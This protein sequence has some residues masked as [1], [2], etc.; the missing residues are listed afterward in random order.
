MAYGKVIH[1]SVNRN[2]F[3]MNSIA[4]FPNF[5]INWIRKKK[6]KHRAEKFIFY[7]T[8]RK[9]R[10][11][12]SHTR[13]GEIKFCFR[14]FPN[15]NVRYFNIAFMFVGVRP[16]GTHKTFIFPF[17]LDFYF[18][19]KNIFDVFDML[20]YERSLLIYCRNVNGDN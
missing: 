18:S 3:I 19:K 2:F 13:K 11:G 15:S 1:N 12:I 16:H 7:I 14:W 10:K 17:F 9:Y 4:I 8:E 5:S 20:M 6:K